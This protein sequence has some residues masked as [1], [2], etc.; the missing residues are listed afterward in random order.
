MLGLGNLEELVGF[1]DGCNVFNVIGRNNSGSFI[2]IF[3]KRLIFRC[4]NANLPMPLVKLMKSLGTHQI[5]SYEHLL[6]V[7]LI[8]HSYFI[9]AL[10]LQAS[11][12]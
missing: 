8:V 10:K 1:G 9:T 6:I 3:N 5:L 7:S 11:E 2:C 4:Y 12:N